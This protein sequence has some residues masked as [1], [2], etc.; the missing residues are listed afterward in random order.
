MLAS[1]PVPPCRAV[2]CPP[3]PARTCAT[4]ATPLLRLEHHVIW[5]RLVKL[6][7]LHPRCGRRCGCRLRHYRVGRLLDGLS[8]GQLGRCGAQGA[9]GG[10][11]VGTAKSLCNGRQQ[12][13]VHTG[14]RHRRGQLGSLLNRAAAAAAA[15]GLPTPLRCVPAPVRAA[16]RGEAPAAAGF[17]AGC[18]GAGLGAGLGAACA[19]HSHACPL[20]SEG[21]N[22]ISLGGLPALW[23]LWQD[24]VHW[25]MAGTSRRAWGSGPHPALLCDG[26][27][28][29]RWPH[30]RMHCCTPPLAS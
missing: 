11:E 17:A 14:R 27:A 22:L 12:G 13:M 9:G 7:A 2:P 28:S 18:L 24:L 26:I 20:S 23:L 4:P 1:H 19:M 5:R 25:A 6:E 21:A 16:A 29:I 3:C 30:G 8:L 15:G 10:W